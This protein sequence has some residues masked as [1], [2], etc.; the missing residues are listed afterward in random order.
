MKRVLAGIDN[1]G[2]A[3]VETAMLLPFYLGLTLCVFGAGF[4]IYTVASLHFAVEA[5]ARCGSV[6]ATQ[7]T[8]TASTRLY[9]SSH[10]YGP[11][12]PAPT[13]TAASAACGSQVNG[14]VTFVF[15]AG[16]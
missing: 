2:A 16:V 10:Y 13:F 15:N 12:T 9:A 7:C 1:R 11:G 14:S 3:A 8:S 6:M 4:L 5:A